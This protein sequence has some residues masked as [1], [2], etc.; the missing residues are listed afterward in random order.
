MNTETLQ[1]VPYVLGHSDRELDRLSLQA[2]TFDP[3]TRQ[4]LREAGI[5]EGMRVLDVGSGSGDV[6]FVASQ[7]VGPWGHVVGVDR[8]PEAVARANVRAQ[9]RDLTNV[10][11][12]QGDPAELEFDQPF[13]A[14]IGRFVLMYYPSPLEALR[15]LSRHVRSE[16]VVAFQELDCANC[17]SLPSA[18]AYDGCAQLLTRT[19]Q[20]TG[21]RTQLGLELYPLY[22]AAGLA[23]PSMRT[24]A[25]VGGGPDAPTYAILAEA[26]HSLLPAIEEFGLETAEQI[27][28]DGLASRLSNEAAASG[29]VTVSF[30]LVGAWSRKR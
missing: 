30:A 8:A 19:L 24:D 25:W 11:F 20:L 28:V 22:L 4:L 21:A 7:L 18:P 15:R 27:D 1:E 14:V 23:A 5:T 3:F 2:K 17:R 16:G 12:V 9:S 26:I 29:G 13:D 10:T 6:A